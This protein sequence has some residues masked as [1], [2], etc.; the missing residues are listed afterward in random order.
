MTES[1]GIASAG[2]CWIQAIGGVGGGKECVKMEIGG[3]KALEQ[4]REFLKRNYRGVS[5]GGGVKSV[6]KWYQICRRKGQFLWGPK[7]CSLGLLAAGFRVQIAKELR[8]CNFCCKWPCSRG[9]LLCKCSTLV[10]G[11]T[12]KGSAS[13]GPTKNTEI[14]EKTQRIVY[15]LIYLVWCIYL[16]CVIRHLV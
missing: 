1:A 12:K 6:W 16:I 13:S 2:S 15:R 9:A 10:S 4:R 3:R 14:T 8:Y 11:P 7:M 5:V